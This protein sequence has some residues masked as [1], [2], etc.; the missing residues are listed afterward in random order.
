MGDV[1]TISTVSTAERVRVAALES[2]ANRGFAQTSLDALG[3]Q[4][5]LTKQA[6]LYHYPSKDRLLEA[7]IDHA[8]RRLEDLLRPAIMSP[9][10]GWGKVERIVRGAFDVAA[11]EPELLGLLREVSRVGPPAATRLTERLRP[12][13]ERARLF[14]EG[15]MA[16]GRLQVHD[17]RV[18][19]IASY[20]MVA[21][22]AT[23]PEVALALGVPPDVR[24]LARARRELLRVLRAAL[25]PL[26]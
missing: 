25:E 20:S 21:G 16:A 24:S 19:L 6:I 26:R 5:G 12:L 15:E 22:V 4:L 11:R 3:E 9:V 8:A 2:F 13:L 14:L 10:V 17:P 7:V 23:E 1:A 18:L